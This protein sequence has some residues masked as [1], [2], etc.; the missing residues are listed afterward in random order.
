MVTLGVR[1]EDVEVTA[2]PASGCDEAQVLVVEPMGSETLVTL[3]YRS[4]RLVARTPGDSRFEPGQAAWVHLP[5][6]RVLTF[7]PDGSRF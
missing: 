1:A 7:K 3:E 4:Q 6:E 5:P 2:A